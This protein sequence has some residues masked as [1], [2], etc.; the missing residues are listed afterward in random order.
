MKRVL[1]VEDHDEDLEI[2]EIILGRFGWKSVG[3]TNLKDARRV[4]EAQSIDAILCDLCLPRQ[5][6]SSGVSALE[7]LKLIRELNNEYPDVSIIGM[8]ALVREEAIRAT[9]YVKLSSLLIKPFG[10]QDLE[11]ELKKIEVRMEDTTK[12][13]VA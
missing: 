8:T 5:F 11:R 2:V 3:V 13:L 1:V 7:G 10:A 4:L 12:V 6:P 9:Q